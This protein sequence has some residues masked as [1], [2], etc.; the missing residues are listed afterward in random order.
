MIVWRS[1]RQSSLK[2]RKT[3]LEWL[4]NKRASPQKA[5]ACFF[6]SIIAFLQSGDAA[7]LSVP[8]ILQG[9]EQLKELVV[10]SLNK[11]E[12]LHCVLREEVKTL[13]EKLKSVQQELLKFKSDIIIGQLGYSLE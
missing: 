3:S 2:T 12:H 11:L 1:M 9:I 4:R 8:T 7:S 10:Y 13:K 5:L 6:D